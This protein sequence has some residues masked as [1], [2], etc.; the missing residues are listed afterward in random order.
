MTS[1]FPGTAIEN[2]LVNWMLFYLVY[3][4]I[5]HNHGFQS[6]FTQFTRDVKLA[7][8]GDDNVC[9]V[10]RDAI[11]Y[12]HFNS[13]RVVAAMYGFTVT[14]AAKA[15]GEQPNHIPVLDC[16]FLKR[17]T[18]KLGSFFVGALDKT[19]IV[20]SLTWVNSKPSYEFSGQWRTLQ[21]KREHEELVQAAMLEVACHG[22]LEYSAFV[23]EI[24]Q[25]LRGT[26]ISPMFE[27]WD[28]QFYRIG[29]AY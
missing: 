4:R 18:Q 6:G 25:S 26:D 14:D 21:G 9:A 15:G 13:F 8:Y 24:R 5:M 17:S 3:R 19:S 27:H 20:K 28:E 10:R 1:G 16:E 7:V 22:P 2:S 12:F 11:S 23:N 29:Y